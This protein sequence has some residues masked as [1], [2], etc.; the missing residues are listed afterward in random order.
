MGLYII[1]RGLP[2]PERRKEGFDWLK[3]PALSAGLAMMLVSWYMFGVAMRSVTPN[4]D[5]YILWDRLTWWTV[6]ISV[7][8]WFVA[9]FAL[10][11]IESQ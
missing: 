6:P 5:Y 3:K 4:I 11:D 2:L 1:T 10:P 9:V 8:L 7:A